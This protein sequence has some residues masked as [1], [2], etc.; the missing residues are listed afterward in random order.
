MGDVRREGRPKTAAHDEHL[1]V[2]KAAVKED[3]RV[4]PEKLK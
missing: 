2:V 3:S 4:T 1:S